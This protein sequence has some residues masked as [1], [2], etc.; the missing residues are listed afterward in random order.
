M[1]GGVGGW[2]WVVG[3]GVGGGV[4]MWYWWIV[5]GTQAQ[6]MSESHTLSCHVSI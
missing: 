3:W 1:G 5:G 6:D 4:G 2:W